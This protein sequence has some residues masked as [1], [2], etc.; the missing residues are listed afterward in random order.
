MSVGT[1][2]VEAGRGTP[3]PAGRAASET[4]PQKR[5]VSR[6]EIIAV[7]RGGDA[8]GFLPIGLAALKQV[9]GDHVLR[10][11][12]AAQF[13]RVGLKTLGK[14]TL[15]GMPAAATADASVKA[16]A[17]LLNALPQ[18]EVDVPD[19]LAV[20]ARNVEALESQTCEAIS[21]EGLDA[22][23][24]ATEEWRELT[25]KERWF[26]ARVGGKTGAV[27]E[28]PSN[29]VRVPAMDL[30]EAA[31]AAPLRCSHLAD[32]V[33]RARGFVDGALGNGGDGRVR[34]AVEGGVV[35]E[36][37]DPPW[38]LMALFEETARSSDGFTPRLAVVQADAMELLDGLACA[39]LSRLI[40]SGRTR[41][42]VGAGAATELETWLW[43][44]SA[45]N[46]TGPVV[47][48]SAIRKRASPTPDHAVESVR[49]RMQA[50]DTQRR[51]RLAARYR[52]RGVAWWRTR[53]D[54]ALDAE[55]R[56]RSTGGLRVLVPTCRYSTY[57]QHASEDF[58]RAVRGLGHEARVLI[59]PDGHSRFSSLA[60]LRE[61]EAFDPDVIVLINYARWHLK[62]VI[63]EGLPFVCWVQDQ[64]P[65]LFDPRVG[66]AQGDLDFVVGH[67]HD[68]L[69][70]RFGYR[71]SHVLRTPMAT[72][73]EKFHAGAIT[74]ERRERFTCELAYV[75]HHSETPDEMHARKLTEAGAS[76][77]LRSVIERIR[78]GIAGVVDSPLAQN[79]SARLHE[80]TYQ[81]MC[82][83]SGAE[84]DAASL[85][86]VVNVYTMPMA[87]RM[88]RHRTLGWAAEVCERKGWRLR[89]YGNGWERHARFGAFAAGAVEHGE[90]LRACYQAAR[91]HLHASIHSVVHQRVM[92]CVLSGGLPLCRI[93]DD[94]LGAM[95]H[96]AM[97]AVSRR[98]EPVACDAFR[99]LRSWRRSDRNVYHYMGYATADHPET[100]LIA[101]TMQRLGLPVEELL[102]VPT[103][104]LEQFRTGDAAWGREGLA[105][106]VLGDLGSCAFHD[107][108][109]LE[110]LLKR[111][112]ED[113]AWRQAA[114][115]GI[116]AR[117]RAR[118][119]HREFAR[120]VLG[121]VRDR[122]AGKGAGA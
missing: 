24:R 56:A 45:T 2:E 117:V 27:G 71:A 102:W 88:F 50:E 38:L 35:V 43:S 112:V 104:K 68:D 91:A 9:P 115:A 23:K 93:H 82:E 8:W 105:F 15:S 85:S 25:A 47:R 14:R 87:D 52:A 46:V 95:R 55:A 34:R 36:G 1:T 6:G 41:F 58:A 122:L 29:L 78:P 33:G 106:E 4:D 39:D 99:E 32:L 80:L 49:A 64:M 61:V 19:R 92:E 13:A 100:M 89:I 60:Y 77:G 79:A 98:E 53:F 90:D 57:V 26:R 42:L 18:D 120:R 74:R 116:A 12:T 113:D 84:P 51:D 17:G 96:W 73:E 70:R 37:V 40:V 75:S 59:E 16:L 7:G 54:A 66:A 30:D 109:G 10:C 97:C 103:N 110:E 63:P 62:G 28:A 107:E 119:T 81:A 114:S 31:E 3:Q 22:L 86:Q 20:C 72:S 101:A 11:L 121:F 44:R 67:A 65:H 111:A 94:E 76:P 108:A 69:T 5:V 21:T 118:T 83:A 48:S